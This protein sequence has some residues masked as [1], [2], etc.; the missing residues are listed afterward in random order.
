MLQNFEADSDSVVMKA[1]TSFIT[2]HSRTYA[3]K[4]ETARRYRIF[5]AN[6]ESVEKHN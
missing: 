5:K 1:F 3:D 6:Y 2:Q 4:K